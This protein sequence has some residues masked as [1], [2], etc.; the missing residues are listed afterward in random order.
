MARVKF[1]FKSN[2][3]FPAFYPL[4]SLMSFSAPLSDTTMLQKN[5]VADKHGKKGGGS[6]LVP[7]LLVEGLYF[8]KRRELDLPQGHIKLLQTPLTP[9]TLSPLAKFPRLN[10]PHS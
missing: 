9:P 8:S 2:Y 10:T 3:E 7:L 5:V 6:L 4:M 1:K